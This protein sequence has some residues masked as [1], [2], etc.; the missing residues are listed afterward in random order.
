MNDKFESDFKRVQKR[1]LIMWIVGLTIVL[2]ML[3]MLGFFIWV[4]VMVMHFFE[5]I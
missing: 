2:G 3:G 1:L 4:I 5:V